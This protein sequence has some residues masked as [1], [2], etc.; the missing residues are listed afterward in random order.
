MYPSA[1]PGTTAHEVAHADFY[2]H[3][4]LGS[5]RLPCS[6]SA[7][8]KWGVNE[9]FAKITAHRAAGDSGAWPPTDDNVAAILNGTTCRGQLGTATGASGCAHDLG[10]LVFEAYEGVVSYVGAVDAYKVYRDALR[11]LKG[12]VVTPAS[13]HEKVGQILE[14]RYPRLNI[15]LPNTPDPFDLPIWDAWW[16]IFWLGVELC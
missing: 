6:E 4:G 10:N 7:I 9:G 3:H 8:K 1:G 15:P 14:E 5:C 13:L 11:R 16:Q 2:K 12:L